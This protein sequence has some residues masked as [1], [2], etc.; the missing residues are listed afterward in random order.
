MI[1][2]IKNKLKRELLAFKNKVRIKERIVNFFY[3][4]FDFKVIKS[5]KKNGVTNIS[6]INP[7]RWHF[8]YRYYIGDYNDSKVFIKV[9]NKKSLL[10]H[11]HDVNLYISENS[12]LLSEITPKVYLYS[13]GKHFS[14]IVEE[15]LNAIKLCDLLNGGTDIDKEKIYIQFIDIIMELQKIKLFHLDINDDNIYIDKNNRAYIT[16]FGYSLIKNSIDTSFIRTS[17]MQE[18][19]YK[20]INPDTRIDNGIIDDAYSILVLSKK[21]DNDMIRNYH[22]YWEKMN[23]L[24]GKMIF[25]YMEIKNENK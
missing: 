9:N 17:K 2:R 5:L 15:Y 24:S 3:R 18:N 20:S 10:K 4:Y 12:K 8:G 11:E 22:E 16:D 21:I 19:I 1:L 23:Q 13:E 14:Y 6:K 25:N 7:A